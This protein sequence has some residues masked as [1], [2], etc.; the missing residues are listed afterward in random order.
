M[1]HMSCM[2]PHMSHGSP[3]I[4]YLL[5]VRT[6]FTHLGHCYTAAFLWACLYCT[7]IGQGERGEREREERHRETGISIRE[8]AT[9]IASVPKECTA[10]SQYAK[11]TN[12]ATVTHKDANRRPPHNSGLSERTCQEHGWIVFTCHILTSCHIINC[13]TLVTT[14]TC[15]FC[16]HFKPFSTQD[17]WQ[18]FLIWHVIQLFVMALI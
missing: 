10:I 1:Q 17:W 14:G 4:C 5:Y 15:Q 8:P 12:L 2:I 18:P 3:A 7:S 6:S 11:P 13:H 9:C 16:A